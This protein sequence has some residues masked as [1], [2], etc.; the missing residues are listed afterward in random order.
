LGELERVSHV[1][2]L[3][4]VIT[5]AEL[6]ERIAQRYPEAAPLPEAPECVAMV[7]EVLGADAEFDAPN[8]RFILRA[9]EAMT[10][11]TGSGSRPTMYVTQVGAQP[12]DSHQQAVHRA[13]EFNREI[14]SALDDR[15][16]LV[17]RV[18][19]I[20]FARA[21]PRLAQAFGVRHVS[22]DGLIVD[23][24]REV[25]TRMRID[26]T[27]VHAADAAWPTGPDTDRL[28]SVLKIVRKDYLAPA[29]LY[30]DGPILV[31]DWGLAFR[32]EMQDLY[33]ELRDACGRGAHPGAL[34]ALPADDAEQSVV[35]DGL[36][37][38]EFL[39]ERYIRV[40]SAWLSIVAA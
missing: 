5:L 40:P 37:F 35:L 26:L 3:R 10:V 13:N 21:V 33:I 2:A 12:F 14:Q 9:A 39:P 23:G 1:R 22:L 7:R 29:L 16:V 24:L 32:Y 17:A 34:C 15:R 18:Q 6:R 38:P 4:R 8:Q 19:P 20:S 28:R 11:Q 36:Q 30:P 25:T 31:T 27:R